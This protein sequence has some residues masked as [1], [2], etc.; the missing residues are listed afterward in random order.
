MKIRLTDPTFEPNPK[1]RVVDIEWAAELVVK[2]GLERFCVAA[3]KDFERV[4]HLT[5]QKKK[6]FVLRV[7]RETLGL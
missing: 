7:L 4:R 1:D 5:F 3:D 6:D 2:N